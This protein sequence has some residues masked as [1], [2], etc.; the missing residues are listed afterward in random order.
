M[1]ALLTS[2][3]DPA[4]RPILDAAT[5]AEVGRAPV[6]TVQDLDRA[7]A[8]AR[9]AQPA[10]AAL[11]HTERSR[12]LRLVADDLDAQAAELGEI[13]TA[14]QGKVDGA[15]E[16]HGAAHWL[17]AAADAVL[18]PQTLS[19]DGAS[20]TELHYLP[21][22]V[23]ASIGPWNFPVMISVWHI[24]PALRMGNTV[25]MKPSEYTPLSV[26]ALAEIFRRHLPADV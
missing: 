7:I 1:N 4:G 6:R 25:V 12:L 10:W 23:V 26:L 22:G 19:E 24:A 16:V 17:R 15:G 8:A 11:G 13:V 2:V 14:E 5:R 9:A 20:R 3:S 21:L 18:E